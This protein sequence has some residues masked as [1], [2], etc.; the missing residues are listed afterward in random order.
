MKLYSIKDKTAELF[1][2]VYMFVNDDVA[3]RTISGS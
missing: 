2:N 1:G 3:K